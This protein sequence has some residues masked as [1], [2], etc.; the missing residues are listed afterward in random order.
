MSTSTGGAKPYVY[1]SP[2]LLTRLSYAIQTWL[3]KSLVKLA[4]VYISIA[5]TVVKVTRKPTYTKVYSVR[6]MI[7][8]RVFIPNTYKAGDKPLPLYINIHGGGFAICEPLF[9]DDVCYYLAQKRGLCVVSIGYRKSPL[10]P[11]PTPVEDCAAVVRAVLAD[12]ELPCDTSKV[13]MGGYSAGGNLS[14]ACSQLEGVKGRIGG[15]V[16]FYPVTD[17]TRNVQT[18]L[19]SRPYVDGQ[20]DML[21]K[22]GYWM[23]WAYIPHG[24]DLANPLL[25]V[26]FARKEDLPPKLC[27][28]GCEFDMLCQEAED[29]A[30]KL[31]ESEKGEKIPLEKGSGWEKGNVRWEMIMGQ[32]HGFDH[33]PIVSNTVKETVERKVAMEMHDTA[34]S[35]LFQKVYT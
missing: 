15:V 30:E 5:T 12:K 27:F 14:L 34:A 3:M 13:A 32:E 6:P 22:S 33:R 2:P 31:A 18:K 29:M 7:T 24:T 4:T 23:N 17:F 21:A 20:K 19:N 26:T 8:N 9:D 1:T 28:F 35:W 25:S 10:H 11:F 16:A